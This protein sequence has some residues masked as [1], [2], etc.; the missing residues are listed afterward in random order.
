[1][2]ETDPLYNPIS[3]HQGTVW[4]LFTGWTAMAEY[5]G[6]R[7]LAGYAALERNVMLT[8]AQDPGAVTELLSGEFYQPLGRSS[9]H[10]LWSSGMVLAP[11]MRGLFGLRP[12]A[13]EHTLV[14]TPHLPAGWDG[15]TLEHVRVGEGL[16]DVT[17]TRRGAA[18]EVV[19]RGKKPGVLCLARELKG[20][21]REAAALEHRMTVPLPEVEV[22]LVTGAPLEFGDVTHQA[23]VVD[24][25]YGA[26]EARL[27]VEAR[28]GDAVELRVRKNRAGAV[29]KVEG[30]EIAG[31]V[32]KV[33]APAG[34][35]WVERDVVVRW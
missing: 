20:E 30:G 34:D 4:P 6:G 13:L 17:M 21:C 14:V 12:A 18:L 11:A 7:P 32:V 9:T 16:W 19:A 35:G 3:Y 2:E 29:V 15:A 26:R 23:R 8:W 33:V 31:D 28:A 1:M 27:K 5:N 25:A 24:E 22:E 10:Q